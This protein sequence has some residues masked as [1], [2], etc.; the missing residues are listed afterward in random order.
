M[1]V[2]QIEDSGPGIPESALPQ[3]FDPFYRVDSSRTR[4]T[5]ACCTGDSRTCRA[6]D[7]QIGRRAG[8]IALRC[9]S[10]LFRGDAQLLQFFRDQECQFQRLRAVE[11]GVAMG[12]IA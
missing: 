9:D 3:L 10:D 1:I 12:V 11:P 7:D 6:T 4:D 2:L 5:G 8:L